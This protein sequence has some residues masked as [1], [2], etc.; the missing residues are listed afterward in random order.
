M[1]KTYARKHHPLVSRNV[2][3]NEMMACADEG[4]LKRG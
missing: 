4:W 3:V 1:S 2:N